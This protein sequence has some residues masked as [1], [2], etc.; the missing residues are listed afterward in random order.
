MKTWKIA[1][2]S[3]ATAVTAALF[4]ATPIPTATSQAAPLPWMDTS[5]TPEQRAD[6]LISAMTLDQKIEQIAN[7]PV[8]N[9]DLDDGDP[10]NGEGCDFTEVGRHIEGIPELQIPDFRQANGGT[11]I[12]GGDCSPEPTATALPAQVASAATFNRRL[13][14]EWGQLLDQEMRAWG[15]HVL[16]GPGMNLIRTP[17]GGRNQEYFSEDPYLTGALAS[18]IVDGIQ[19]RRISQATIKHFVANDSEYQFERWTSANRVPPRAMHELYLLPFEMAVKDADPASIMCAYPHVNFSYNCDSSPLLQQTLRQ[20]WGFDGYVFSDRRAQQS[21]VP[22]VLAGVD[23]EL[24]E[25]PEWYTPERIKAAINSGEITEGHI[26]DLLRERYVKMFE[27]GDFDDPY[28][29]FQWDTISFSPE[30]THAQLAKQ[31]AAESLVLLRNDRNILPLNA[32]A[33]SSI[34]LI[35][36]SWFAGEATLPPR[37]GDRFDNIGVVEPYQVTPEQGLHNALDS[38]GSDATVTYNDGDDISSAEQLAADSDVTIL[39]VGDVARETWDKNGNVDQENPSGSVAGA[40]NEVADLDLPSVTGTN[41]QLLIPRILAANPNTIVV[42]KTEGQVNM[43]WINDVHT[44]VQAWYPGQEDGNV[45][46]DA[47]FGRTNFSGKLPL[48]IGRTDREAAYQTPAQYPGFE[49]QTG[50][51]GGYG[52]DPIPGQPQRVVRYN[53]DL[54][55]GYRWYEATGT[56]PLFPFGFG[57]SYTTFA[58]SDLQVSPIGGDHGHGGLKVDYTITNTGSRPGKEASQ[59]Y[60]TLPSVAAEPSRRLVGFDKVD[61]APGQSKRVSVIIDADASNHPFSYWVPATTTDLTKWADGDWATANGPYTV[62]VGGSSASTPLNQA[63]RLTFQNTAPTARDVTATVERGSSVAIG[64]DA[65]DPDGDALSYTYSGYDGHTVTPIG[66]GSAIRFMPRAGFTGAT[67]FTYTVSDGHGGTASA[68]VRVAVTQGEKSTSKIRDVKVRPKR[69]T[70]DDRARVTFQV[71]SGGAP[72]E[73]TFTV[74]EGRRTLGGGTLDDR[75]RGADRIRRLDAG[76]H[77]VKIVYA[78]SADSE[79]AA[80]TVTV[81]VR[82]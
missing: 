52:R 61:L 38:L 36:P 7:R 79:R 65:A 39:M 50:T 11:G 72:A 14:Y 2:V 22:S 16:W 76:R 60:L 49:E 45:V 13:N 77:H 4:L 53:E 71:R 58:Y 80:K 34:A 26:D 37:S 59:V 12:R 31:A 17:Y 62:H 35:G 48:T 5:K 43:P 57:L 18:Q 21:T 68:T 54:T 20:S 33:V 27:F 8:Y 46:A 51:P 29:A 1:S 82:R 10:D 19:A 42:M 23:V 41:Q 67:S 28:D 40:P 81:R 64:L 47:L 6:L 70:T 24:D 63:V 9:A 30:A 3:L 73:G 15:H 74:R 69:L 32:Q 78:G 55:M 66:D 25:Q 44:M 56:Q 75:G